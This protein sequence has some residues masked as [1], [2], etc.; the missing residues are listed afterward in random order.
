[1]GEGVGPGV[2][3][4]VA[5]GAELHE[6]KH[7]NNQVGWRGRGDGSKCGVSC[8]VTCRGSPPS[9]SHFA[10]TPSTQ[11]PHFQVGLYRYVR[12]TPARMNFTTRRVEL[13]GGPMLGMLSVA[14][15]LNG[16]SYFIPRLHI[17]KGV[18]PLVRGERGGGG[19]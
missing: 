12:N 2:G 11:T 1:M 8:R 16:Y 9:A 19:G 3:A 10:S 4:D 5:E 6:L 13:E 17:A 14:T 15:L 7:D 18:K